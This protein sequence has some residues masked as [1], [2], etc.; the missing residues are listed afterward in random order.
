MHEANTPDRPPRRFSDDENILRLL[1]S[2]EAK[3]LLKFQSG[4]REF[5]VVFVQGEKING[6]KDRNDNDALR[7]GYATLNT[8][9]AVDC[10]D[11][12]PYAVWE[13]YASADNER[14]LSKAIEVDADHQKQGI[15]SNFWTSMRDAGYGIDRSGFQSAAGAAML[16]RIDASDAEADED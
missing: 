10:A 14:K 1:R 6:T 7:Y 16:N 4:D 15:G 11:N 12:R 3:E 5:K 2:S 13:F 8:I 9:V